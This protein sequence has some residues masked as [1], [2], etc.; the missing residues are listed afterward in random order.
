MPSELPPGINGYRRQQSRWARGSLECAVLHLPAVLSAPIP[1]RRRLWAAL[2]LTGYGIHLLL[3]ALSILY[4]LMLRVVEVQPGSADALG[5]LG[6]FGIPAVAP[7]ILFLAGQSILARPRLAALPSVLL[8]SLVGVGM[9]VNTGRAALEA[10]I[11]VRGRFERTPKYGAAASGG[12]WRRLGYQVR[13]DATVLGELVL[14]G[15]NAGTA[16]RALDGGFWAIAFFA[17]LFA[18]GLALVAGLTIA[19]AMRGA[20][21]RRDDPERVVAA[22]EPLQVV[23][24]D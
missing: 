15:F 19:E 10:A 18:A 7:T 2:H 21:A 12:G 14:A 1:A 22:F 4:P 3:L 9:M 5:L 13:S 23:A 24:D 6:V 20:W 16:L 8:L 17:A 11:G